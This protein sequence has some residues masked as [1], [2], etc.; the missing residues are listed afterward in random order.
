MG[1]GG[2]IAIAFLAF[3]AGW[4]FAVA[5]SGGKRQEQIMDDERARKN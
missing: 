5:L 3:M 1:W 4:F 2:C